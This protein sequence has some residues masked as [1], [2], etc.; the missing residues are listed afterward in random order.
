[1]EKLVEKAK[2]GDKEA[3][4]E[5]IFIIKNDLYK[6]AKA[7]L[8]NKEDDIC[9]VV[10]DTIISAYTSIR[11]LKKISH[12]KSWI[13]KIL[14]NKCNDIFK[15]KSVYNEISFESNQYENYLS[16]NSLNIQEE[17]IK[18]DDL[19]SILNSE[20]RT[21]MVLHYINGYNSNEIGKILNIKS[22]TIRSKI[23]RARE[24]ILKEFKEEFEYDE[25]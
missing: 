10:Q 6:I 22:N 1:M 4:C 17:K 9:D 8:G 2:N 5:L 12:F 21:I 25:L 18:F 13:I 19:M 24:K 14:I 23:S 7:R 15:K 16:D 11:K 3:F 20:E